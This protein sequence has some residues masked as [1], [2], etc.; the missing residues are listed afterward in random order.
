MLAVTP[1][2]PALLYALRGRRSGVQTGDSGTSG[3]G[4]S[5]IPP[6]APP[7]DSAGD[8]CAAA[9]KAVLCKLAWLRAQGPDVHLAG[10]LVGSRLAAS[11]GMHAAV[12]VT[13][14]S[15]LSNGSL[16]ALPT[17]QRL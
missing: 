8:S 14:L 12:Q 15:W 2:L 9:D 1:V 7:A 3:G 17:T 13:A 4:A 5:G 6:A 11:A 10:R 16:T